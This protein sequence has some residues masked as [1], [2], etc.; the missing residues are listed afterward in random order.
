MSDSSQSTILPARFEDADL[1]TIVVLITDMLQRLINHN[2][3]IPLSPESLTRFH[4]RSPPAITV[5]EY[6]RRIAKY[7]NVER[8]CLL[9]TL[10]YI[11]QICARLARFTISSLTVHRF[12]ISSIAVSS[13][14]LCDVFCTNSHYAKVG[15]LRVVE[16]NV[17]EKELLAAIDWRLTCTR[18]LLQEYYVNLVRTHSSGIYRIE[19][20][21]QPA[22]TSPASELSRSCTSSPANEPMA[23][24]GVTDVQP[25]VIAEP[26]SVLM[27]KTVSP[28]SSPPAQTGPTALEQNMAFAALQVAMS[29]C[30]NGTILRPEKR[31]SG[32]LTD[33][34]NLRTVKRK[35]SP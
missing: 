5:L 2:D 4:S 20:Q 29:P 30:V 9:I 28:P 10:H 31:T 1:D 18:E 23:Q 8:T 11:D 14:A 16:L 22:T 3:K 34:D 26:S 24:H 27:G 15:G 19:E 7:T 6:L 12:I 35:F 33:V 13:K 25:L 32:H 21:Q 17:L